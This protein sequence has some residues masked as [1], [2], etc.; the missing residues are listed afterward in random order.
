MADVVEAMEGLLSLFKVITLRRLPSMDDACD[1]GDGGGGFL[2][3][4]LLMIG[5]DVDFCTWIWEL[6]LE[7]L[8][9]TLVRGRFSFFCC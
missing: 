2:V 7:V 8:L 1:D 5:V 9:E 3:R 4:L 6:E